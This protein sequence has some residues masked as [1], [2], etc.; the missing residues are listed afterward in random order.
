MPFYL[1]WV[2]IEVFPSILRGVGDVLTPSLILAGGICGFRILWLFTAFQL[3]P[4]L[5]TLCVC[6]PLSWVV[7]DMAVYLYFRH[8]PIMTRAVRVIDSDYDHRAN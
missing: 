4:T 3:S 1:I 8:S 7:T 5:L 6:Y 2:P